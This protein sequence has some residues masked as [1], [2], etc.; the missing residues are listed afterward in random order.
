VGACD[1]TSIGGGPYARGRMRTIGPIPR[2]EMP[3]AVSPA[4]HRIDIRVTRALDEHK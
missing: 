1:K 3:I 2:L 4:P